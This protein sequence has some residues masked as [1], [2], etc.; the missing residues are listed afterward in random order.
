[1][2]NADLLKQ[3]VELKAQMEELKK[4]K[5]TRGIDAQTYTISGKI[6]MDDV[7]K[8]T[9]NEKGKSLCAQAKYSLKAIIRM[10]DAAS[11]T[12]TFT[13]AQWGEATELEAPDWSI[14]KQ[15]GDRINQWYHHQHNEYQ[16]SEMTVNGERV[17][18]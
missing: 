15:T 8:I 4:P 12:C 3:I 9:I 1:M 10:R 14:Y 13:R 5:K 2:T 18:I 7:D 16:F 6:K 11:G 17:F